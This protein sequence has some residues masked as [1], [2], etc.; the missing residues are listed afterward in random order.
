MLLIQR[1]VEDHIPAIYAIELSTQAVAKTVAEETGAR[2]LTLHSMQT[3]T[4][5]EFDASETYV[6]IMTRNLEAVREGLN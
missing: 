6:S 4:Q 1:V 2:I 3:V 5:E